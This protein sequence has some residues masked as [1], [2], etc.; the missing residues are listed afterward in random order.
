MPMPGIPNNPSGTN[1]FDGLG[2]EEPYGQATKGRAL[3]AGA[4]LAGGKVAAGAVNAPKRAQRT[5][6]RGG[7]QPSHA[8]GQAAQ[9]APV[10]QQG[11]AA[12]VPALGQIW[13][14]IASTPGAEQ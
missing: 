7:G 11:G 8:A 6:T 12:P 9:L 14:E 10:P 1:G 4:P 13:A 2:T 3:A 5:A